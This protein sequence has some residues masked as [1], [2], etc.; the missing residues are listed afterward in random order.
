MCVCVCVWEHVR[1]ASAR[2]SLGEA[3]LTSIHNLC[4]GLKIRKKC[5]YPCIPPFYYIKVG[6]KKVFIARTCFPD[7]D[8]V[9]IFR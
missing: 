5:V 4:F 6:F 9:E 8:N 7:G 1:T 2:N 3:V